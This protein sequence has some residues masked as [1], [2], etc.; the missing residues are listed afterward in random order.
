MKHLND[1]LQHPWKGPTITRIMLNLLQ[2]DGTNFMMMITWDLFF[3][4]EIKKEPIHDGFT[5]TK[6]HATVHWPERSKDHLNDCK[7]KMH[8]G[9]RPKVYACARASPSCKV[10]V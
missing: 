1:F 2:L 9:T 10:V 4:E 6:M 5:Q 8:R 7:T 3:A